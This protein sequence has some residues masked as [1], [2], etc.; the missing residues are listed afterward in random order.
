MRDIHSKLKKLVQ[1]VKQ[2]EQDY[3]KNKVIFK[4]ISALIIEKQT[5]LTQQVNKEFDVF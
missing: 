4:L 5:N 1:E 2:K 3:A